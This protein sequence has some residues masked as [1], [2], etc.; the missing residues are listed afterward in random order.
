MELSPLLIAG[1]VLLVVVLGLALWQ[2]RQQV[3]R[4]AGVRAAGDLAAVS[5]GHA[6]ADVSKAESQHLFAKDDL[7]G[8]M[9]YYEGAW[10]AEDEVA[11]GDTTVNVEVHGSTAGLTGA[12]R[13]LLRRAIE[14]SHDLDRRAREVIQRELARRGIHDTTMEPYEL[15]VRPRQDG[16]EAGFVW[17]EV[18]H[19]DR[20]MGVSSSDGWRTLEVETLD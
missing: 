9:E 5:G 16:R 1:V 6:V 14:S 11:F 15:A 8:A 13:D 18:E 19:A 20:E 7:L 4:T 3:D 12:Q 17:Y 10:T 2:R